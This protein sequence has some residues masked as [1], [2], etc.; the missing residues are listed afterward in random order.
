MAPR[1]R[2]AGSA[3]T[4]SSQPIREVDD[5]TSTSDA[6]PSERTILANTQDDYTRIKVENNE[7]SL[8]EQLL[9][10]QIKALQLKLR[11]QHAGLFELNNPS[12][13]L[14]ANA[15][16]INNAVEEFEGHVRKYSGKSAREYYTW[17]RALEQD[18][19]FYSLA[20]KRDED[21]VHYA[22]R[23]L[24]TDS[25]AANHWR[26]F[27]DHADEESLTW[28]RMKE[29]MLNILGSQ[30]VRMQTNFSK[31]LRA[32]WRNDPIALSLYL[33]SLETQMED[34]LPESTKLRH[35]QDKIP[36]KLALR[37]R[38]WPEAKTRAELVNQLDVI[39]HD[40]K[41]IEELQAEDGRNSHEKFNPKDKGKVKKKG[42]KRGRSEKQEGSKGGGR[43]SQSPTNPKKNKSFKSDPGKGTCFNCGEK[44]HFAITCS[45]PPRIAGQRAKEAMQARKMVRRG[46]ES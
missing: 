21:K 5:H 29:E 36:A 10:E 32:Q 28:N 40:D 16:R 35:F 17:V 46:R 13:A 6:D 41:R 31:W 14:D 26:H 11:L 9:Q 42:L 37:L 34:Q 23:T 15:N 27:Q 43:D 8:R 2:T 20:L 30:D 39:I 1:T 25:K 45:N 4:S 3:A 12:I 38:V 22:Q 33:A 18:H 19:K 44:G 24:V 7:P